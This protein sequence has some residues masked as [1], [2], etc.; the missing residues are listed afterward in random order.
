MHPPHPLPRYSSPVWAR[1]SAAI[2]ANA[3]L[4]VAAVANA[5]AAVS[6]PVEMV[7]E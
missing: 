2:S 3:F 5:D 7:L 6:S 4:I 1:Y